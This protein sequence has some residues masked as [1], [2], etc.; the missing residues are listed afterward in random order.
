MSFPHV[1]VCEKCRREI[2]ESLAPPLWQTSQEL[3][4]A[5]EGLANY[6]W[7]PIATVSP[8]IVGLFWIRPG[9]KEDGDWYV[10][11]SGNPILAHCPPHIHMGKYGSWSSL[12]LA[13]H[14][15]PIPPPP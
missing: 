11:T 4:L 9:T 5:E 8:S 13:T 2:G 12:M 10:D 1:C 15:M 3:K 6:Q 14:W 7:Q